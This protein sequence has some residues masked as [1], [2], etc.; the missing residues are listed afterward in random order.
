MGISTT[1]YGHKIYAELV[2]NCWKNWRFVDTDEL[3]DE[4]IA[5]RKCPKCN[6]C[7]TKEGHDPC[8]ANLPG[9]KAACCGHGTEE[10][11]FMF[12]NGVVIRGK[13]TEIGMNE[14]QKKE[15]NENSI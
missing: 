11:Y 2:D 8:I 6:K 9:V 5:T 3:Y 10:G 1:S 4:G 12:E 15:Y 14:I 13:F 7:P